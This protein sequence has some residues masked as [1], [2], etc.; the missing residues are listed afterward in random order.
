MR[1]QGITLIE[2]VVL[3]CIALIFTAIAI[4][5]YFTYQIR[6][7]VSKAYTDMNRLSKSIELY[8]FD[9]SKQ[10]YPLKPENQNDIN[11]RYDLYNRLYRLTSPK[12][13]IRE[14]PTDPFSG[15]DI[16]Y[17]NDKLMYE[18]NSLEYQPSVFLIERSLLLKSKYYL[19]SPGPDNKY[20]EAPITSQDIYDVSNGMKS[21]GDLIIIKY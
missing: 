21:S 15:L 16:K 12:R 20:E 11:N 10:L 19:R 8:R 1:T 6:S 18:Y 13:F 14:L 7:N 17:I 5:N 2:M 3:S 9:Y 4:P